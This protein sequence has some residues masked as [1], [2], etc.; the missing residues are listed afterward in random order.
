MK[1]LVSLVYSLT[2]FW[3]FAARASFSEY[4]ETCR[5]TRRQ[6]NVTEIQL[7]VGSQLSHGSTIFGSDDKRYMNATERWSTFAEPH[8]EVVIEPSQEYDVSK[9]VQY[10]NENSIEFLAINRGHGDTQSVG[11]FNGVQI[12]LAKLRN[13]TIQP[14]GKSALFQ[15]GV[16]DGQALN[17]LWNQGYVATTGACDCVGLMGAGAGGG[18]GPHE[19][20]YGMISDNFRQLNVVLADE[21]AVVVSDTSHS[22]LFWGMKGAGH[23]FGIVTSFEMNI[24]PRGPDTWHYHNYIWRG[25]KLEEVFNTLNN[26]HGNG[27]TPVG[28][29]S[30]LGNFGM[31]TTVSSTE[32]VIWWSFAYRGTGEEAERYLAPFNAIGATYDESG[33]VP[34]PVISIIQGNDENGF[35]CRGSQLRITATAG[36][37][38]YNTTAERQ[39]FDGFKQQVTTN[40][41]LAARA[42]IIHEGYSTEA[43]QTRDSD[44]S[45]FPFRDD[46]HLML[47]LLTIPE[48]NEAAYQAAWD[49]GKEIQDQW[50]DG[51]PGRPVDAYVNYANGFESL[52]QRYGHEPWRL[53]RLR[54][55]KAKYDPLN[56]FRYYN[57]IIEEP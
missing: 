44:N 29:A 15:G 55:L 9:I 54:A 27:S 7:E 42:A 35:I 32:P 3:P 38:T 56:R 2:V 51:Q 43:V 22:D 20:F 31:N 24:F 11:S 17:Y 18:H 16:Y 45:A 34:F 48:G 52:E 5:I 57:P 36:L 6:L 37:Q 39:I 53:E 26:L 50:N 30:N 10:C 49:W 40:P 33:D 47:A 41:E 25:D 21:T 12:N 8:V 14:D 13:I 1:S 28:M 23:N 46:H 19:G 4:F